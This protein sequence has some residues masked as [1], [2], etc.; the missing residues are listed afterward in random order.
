MDIRRIK[1]YVS[2][3]FSA[4]SR[5]EELVDTVEMAK[6][7]EKIIKEW[8]SANENYFYSRVDVKNSKQTSGLRFSWDDSGVFYYG[9]GFED[10][11]LKMFRKEVSI[12]IGFKKRISESATIAELQKELE[13]LSIEQIPLPGLVHDP[14]WIIKPISKDSNIKKDVDIISFENGVLN[15]T[16]KSKFTGIQGYMDIAYT[17]GPH[18]P[19]GTHFHVKENFDG[20]INIFIRLVFAERNVLHVENIF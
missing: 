15:F 3:A 2:R 16:V 17:C 13:Y 10:N 20:E 19:K 9:P 7:Q 11:D 14:I 4:F 8:L 6:N 1:K 18:R 5:N 12:S